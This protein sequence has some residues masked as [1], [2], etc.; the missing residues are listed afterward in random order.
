MGKI[1]KI[2]QE[3]DHPE[4]EI[5]CEIHDRTYDSQVLHI[6]HPIFPSPHLIFKSDG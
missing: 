3:R 1:L 2:S 4:K 5:I 6:S